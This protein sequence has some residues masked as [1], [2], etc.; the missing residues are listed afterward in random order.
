LGI[1]DYSRKERDEFGAITVIERGYTN[2]IKYNAEIRTSD[3][4]L[5]RSLLANKRAT[6]AKYIGNANESSTIVVGYI[7]QFN[8]KIED[9]MTSKLDLE[10]E[11]QVI[12]Q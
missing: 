7:T 3:A 12:T 8:I 1:V 2:R 11:G 10:V 6:L 4:G 9:F 5:V